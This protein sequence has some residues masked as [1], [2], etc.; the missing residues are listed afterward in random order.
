M[1]MIIQTKHL[2]LN[3]PTEN[4][5]QKLLPIYRKESN[6]RFIQNGKHDWTLAELKQKYKLL[7]S[8]YDQGFG[9]W[10]VR[11]KSTDELIGEAG[12]L[13]TK[14]P[15]EV[16][17]IGYMLDDQYWSKGLGTQLCKALISYGRTTLRLKKVVAGTWDKNVAS[18]K[19][20]LK[21]GLSFKKKITLENGTVYQRFEMELAA[22]PNEK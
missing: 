7:T 11:H 17:E 9:F 14:N 22:P 4:C 3:Q 18:Q 19:V 8:H 13:M 6:M 16:L 20:L 2:Y 15:K 10:M 1:N 21:C 12:F 5:Y